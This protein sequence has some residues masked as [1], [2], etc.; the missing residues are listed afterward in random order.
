MRTNS[1]YQTVAAAIRWLA[2]HQQAQPDLQSLADAVGVSPHHLQRTFTQWAGVSPKQFLKHLT[3]SAALERLAL[4]R[5]VLDTSLE[6]GLSGPGRL[7]DL[8]ISTEAVT[9][10]QA[11]SGGGGVTFCHGSG[12][13]PFGPATVVWNDRGLGFLG[14]DGAG[15]QPTCLDA[16]R[17]QWPAA[18]FLPDAH[19]AHSWL[20]AIFEDQRS[21]PLRLWVQG[22]PFRLKV[23]EALLRIPPGALTTYGDLA[24]HLGNPGAARAVGTAVGANPLAWLI[25]CHRVI[26][27]AGEIGNYR[28]GATTKRAMV[29]WEAAN[30]SGLRRAG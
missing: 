27:E 1:Q 8:L 22:T 4:G 30:Q 9:P 19:R 3:R 24:R 16:A 10:G 20:S 28:W 7:H 18:K 17:R 11:R 6:I 21:R 12:D 15:G 23:W 25:P 2:E 5:T 13:S 29:A 26:R 14:F